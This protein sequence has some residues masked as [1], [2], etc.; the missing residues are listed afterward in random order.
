MSLNLALCDLLKPF[1]I[2]LGE[3]LL[4]KKHAEIDSLYL[5]LLVVGSDLGCMGMCAIIDIILSG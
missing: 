4:L 3:I 1:V 5:Q 2:I